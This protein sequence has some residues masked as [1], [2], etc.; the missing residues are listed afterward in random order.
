LKLSQESPFSGEAGFTLIEALVALAIVA[1][2]LASIGGIVAT[3]SRGT[4]SASQRV[5]LAAAAE[6]LLTELPARNL[7]VPG[8]QSGQK[9][10]N[11]WNVDITAVAV[12]A[13]SRWAPLQVALEL[14]AP[15]GMTMKFTTVRLIPVAPK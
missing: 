11:R 8:H 9:D 5:A 1:I 3:V 7:L 4:R 13:T 2:A 15:T 14:R 10:G 6:S 12:G